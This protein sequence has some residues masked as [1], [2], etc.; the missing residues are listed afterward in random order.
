MEQQ[1]DVVNI[2]AR[3]RLPES[4]GFLQFYKWG[5]F[6]KTVGRTVYRFGTAT[7]L[8][9]VQVIEMLLPLGNKYWYVPR[10][11]P[12]NDTIRAAQEQGILFLRYEPMEN[13]Y[14]LP[15][16]KP[17][18]PV[19]PPATLI[20]DLTKNEDDLLTN[21][22]E[23]T[24]YNIRLAER[25]GVTV[26]KIPLENFEVFWKLMEE[27]ARRDKFRTHEKEYYKTM[28]ATLQSQTC[29]VELWCAAWQG[30]PLAVGLWIYFGEMVTYLHGASSSEDRNLMAPYLL[31]WEVIKDAK[32]HGYTRYDFWGIAPQK[33]T[34]GT[35]TWGGLTRFKMGFGG[36]VIQFPGTFDL[37]ISKLGYTLYKLARKIRR[38]G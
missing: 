10:G 19:S 17:T 22:H 6:Q 16:S 36:E 9:G 1:N 35:E 30:K 33:K 14:V 32:A 3:P 23:K 4:G 2:E 37:P 38:L 12:N 24:R 18:F 27:T 7:N 13:L 25:K 26:S 15:G 29:K 20:L 34:T 28:V 5:D 11:L 31:H 8:D 21:M